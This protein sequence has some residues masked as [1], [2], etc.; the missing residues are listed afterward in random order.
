MRLLGISRGVDR[1]VAV[2][3]LGVLSAVTDVL[4]IGALRDSHDAKVTALSL[5][6]GVVGGNV[7]GP[8]SVVSD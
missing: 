4:G 3:A 2:A 8:E 1:R 7:A 5:E 6:S